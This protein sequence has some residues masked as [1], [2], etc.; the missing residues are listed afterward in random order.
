MALALKREG[1]PHLPK[2]AQEFMK[3]AV[4]GTR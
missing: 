4:A 3:T 1:K 2:N